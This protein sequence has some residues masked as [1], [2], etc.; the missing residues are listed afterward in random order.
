MK[1]K[2]IFDKDNDD[3]ITFEYEDGETLPVEGDDFFFTNQKNQGFKLGKILYNKYN[4][5]TFEIIERNV[6]G[7]YEEI[8]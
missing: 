5:I 1:L 6:E 3:I 2:S 7:S 4:V 8:D